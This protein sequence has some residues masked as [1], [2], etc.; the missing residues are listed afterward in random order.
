MSSTGRDTEEYQ[1]ILTRYDTIIDQLASARCS[2]H[3]ADKLRGKELITGQIYEEALNVGP[4]VV[5][6]TRI[7]PMIN[8]VLA[9]VELNTKNYYTFVGV[10]REIEGAADIVQYIIQGIWFVAN[11]ISI[12][13]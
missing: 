1:K 2:G 13:Y 12:I 11:Y 3:L 7:R 4:G 8:A 10:L 5:E 6:S 9:K